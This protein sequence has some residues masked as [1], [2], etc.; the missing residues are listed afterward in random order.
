[1]IRPAL[2]SFPIPGLRLGTAM[3]AIRKPNRRDLLVMLL[4]E[5]SA[6]AGVFT[7]NRFCAAPVQL[8][9]AHLASGQATPRPGG[10]HG[11]RERRHRR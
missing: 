5:G 3:A 9:R 10:E 2:A 6:A 8:C 7:S 11:Q 1:M 4:D